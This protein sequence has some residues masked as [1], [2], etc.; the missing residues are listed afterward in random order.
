[1]SLFLVASL[2]ILGIVTWI[3][4]SNGYPPLLVFGACSLVGLSIAMKYIELCL[5]P[6]LDG[7]ESPGAGGKDA[8]RDFG[9]VRG[10][11][12][13]AQYTAA[14]TTILA[15]PFLR[16]LELALTVWRSLVMVCGSK[17]VREGVRLA[18][19]ACAGAEPRRPYLV[20]A[21]VRREALAFIG[22]IRAC[23]ALTIEVVGCIAILWVARDACLYSPVILHNLLM[24]HHYHHHHLLHHHHE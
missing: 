10:V 14:L 18:L 13:V 1:M 4:W 5:A 20:E 11:E 9:V 21:D 12:G 19:D 8:E 6:S 17:T 22:Q 23:T 7:R 3:L 15:W 2:T 16:A 24:H